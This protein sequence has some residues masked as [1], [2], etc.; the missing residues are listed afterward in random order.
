MI[1][2]V[3]SPALGVNLHVSQVWAAMLREKGTI[4]EPSLPQAVKELKDLLVHTH[5]MDYK[6]A[7]EVPPQLGRRASLESAFYGERSSCP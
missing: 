7:A 2:E 1:E 3:A 4:T 5:L 6:L